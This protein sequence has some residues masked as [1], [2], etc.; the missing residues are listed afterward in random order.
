[1][2]AIFICEIRIR[3]LVFLNAKDSNCHNFKTVMLETTSNS[4]LSHKGFRQTE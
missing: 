3:L 2:Q 4:C 1:V